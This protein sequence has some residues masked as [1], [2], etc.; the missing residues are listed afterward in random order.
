MGEIVRS[1]SR[2]VSAFK[3]RDLW[4]QMPLQ[5]EL[6]F[7]TRDRRFVVPD[8]FSRVLFFRWRHGGWKKEGGGK[9]HEWHPSQKGVLDPPSYGTFS[10][11]LRCHCSV[12]PVQESTTEQSRSSFGGVQ[13]FSGERV[14]WYVFP[15]P[16]VLHPPH[17]TAQFFPFCPFCWPPLFLPFSRHLFALFSPSKSAA[18]FCREKGTEQ[19]LERGS[20]GMHLST[21]FGKEIPSRNLREKRSGSAVRY[22]KIARKRWRLELAIQNC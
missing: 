14:L 2:I 18:L 21:N 6:R 5:I 3:T 4:P 7:E 12:F 10:T 15:P 8:L 20:S 11:P 17:I 1:K 9:P 19:S 16:Y 22:S 13:K